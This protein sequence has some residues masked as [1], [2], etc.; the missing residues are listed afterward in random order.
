MK[1]L[2]ALIAFFALPHLVFSQMAPDVN[3]PHFGALTFY[4][5]ND[6]FAGTDSDYTNG[7]RISWTSPNVGRF[8]DDP[9]AGGLAGI[10]DDA[11]GTGDS[12]YT[13][14][15]AISIGQCLYTPV[16]TQASALVANERPY[17]GWLY[18]GLGLVWKTPRV[19]NTLVFNIGV[20]GPWAM[21]EETQ[22]AVH[23]SLGQRSP[24]GW[25]NQL[26][27]EVGVT[28]TYERKW[29]FRSNPEGSGLACDFLPYGGA[30]VGNVYTL[31]T[32]GGQYRFGY[33]LPDDFG[34]GAISDSATTPT[35]VEGSGART[36]SQRFGVHMFARAEGRAVARN[37]FLDGNTFRSSHS[38]DKN[39][40]VA[41]L[42][43]G[44]AMN[45]RNSK[46]SYAFIYRTREF[47]G[48]PEGQLFGSVTL[49]IYF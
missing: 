36:W 35:P 26:R 13:R 37:I 23:D 7:A 47:K 14:N 31:A 2:F 48:Q 45:W 38:V 20:I 49:S 25:D 16:N 19:K 27:N 21:G 9:T 46:L 10:F 44:V 28:A 18:T 24:Q 8:G 6:A 33:N 42:S 32:L 4:F 30:T 41:D 12:S 34:T 43:L 11:P 15:V 3:P 39:I 5:E 1:T 22:R 17:A 29:R 40:F